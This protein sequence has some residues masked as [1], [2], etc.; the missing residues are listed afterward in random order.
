MPAFSA[1]ADS[2]AL[3]NHVIPPDQVPPSLTNLPYTPLQTPLPHQLTWACTLPQGFSQHEQYAGIF[4]FRFWFGRWIEIV[5][6]DL[7]PCRKGLLIYMK[8]ASQ[9]SHSSAGI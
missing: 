9:V 2:T 7:L 6:D 1:I 8:S 5:I 3:L 4:H